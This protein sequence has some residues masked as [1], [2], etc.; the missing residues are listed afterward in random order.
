M[1]TIAEVN[2]NTMDTCNVEHKEIRRAQS[3]QRTTSAAMAKLISKAQAL[4]SD[5][6]KKFPIPLLRRV[7]NGINAQGQHD[8]PGFYVPANLCE[9]SQCNVGSKDV[10]RSSPCT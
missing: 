7:S 2:H 3:R 10:A 1:G 6:I 5:F 9:P 4:E 8:L